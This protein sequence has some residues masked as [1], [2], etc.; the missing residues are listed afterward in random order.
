MHAKDSLLS[1]RFFTY[2]FPKEGLKQLDPLADLHCVMFY[3]HASLIWPSAE[4]LIRYINLDY[5]SKH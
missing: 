2:N 1:L 4:A 3:L 5:F